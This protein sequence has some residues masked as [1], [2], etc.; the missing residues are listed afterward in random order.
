MDEK[1][2][3][4]KNRDILSLWIGLPIKEKIIMILKQ[5]NKEF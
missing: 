1:V 4:I 2:N 3:K 5:I